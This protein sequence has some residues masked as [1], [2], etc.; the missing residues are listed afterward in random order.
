MDNYEI[1]ILKRNGNWEKSNQK[2]QPINS[3]K[4]IEKQKIN[5]EIE[6][7]SNENLDF[8]KSIHQVNLI[9]DKL[10]ILENDKN[11]LITEL[12]QYE[13]NFI[14]KKNIAEQKKSQISKEIEMFD[15]TI[16]VIK[17][18]KKF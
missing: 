1:K 15:K 13:K 2:V 12:L 7:T 14:S 9:I 17:N 6:N 11:N 16:D 4:K 10:E 18:L 8:L 3:K 5:T